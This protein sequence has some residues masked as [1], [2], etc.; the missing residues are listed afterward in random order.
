MGYD[1]EK[2]KRKVYRCI[3][4]DV[5]HDIPRRLAGPEWSA[6]GHEAG[7]R[8]L[9]QSPRV[10]RSMGQLTRYPTPL[11]YATDFEPAVHC[12]ELQRARRAEYNAT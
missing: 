3:K 11:E 1:L 10:T 8:G 12:S 5:G 7:S 6:R 9:P 2:M 4:E